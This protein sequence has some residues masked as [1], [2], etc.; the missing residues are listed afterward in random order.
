[1]TIPEQAN[2]I[3][4]LFSQIWRIFLVESPCFGLTY[5]DITIGVFVLI[6]LI[7]LLKSI[8]TPDMSGSKDKGS[9]RSS[10]D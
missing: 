4:F 7:K 5:A 10:N 8:F 6:F 1:M 9:G 2:Y 3:S